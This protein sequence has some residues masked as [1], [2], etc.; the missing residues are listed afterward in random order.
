[1]SAHVKHALSLRELVRRFPHAGCLEAIVT[2]P[3]AR[4]PA[5]TVQEG[6]LEVGRGLVGDRR[7]QKFS[8]SAHQ[9]KRELTL[10][11]AEHLPLI[12]RRSDDTPPD[13]S[14][15]RRNLVVSGINLLAMRAPFAD[16]ALQW[17]IGSEAIIE[18]TGP[19][20]PCSRMEQEF[21]PGG[22]NA[23]RGHS[24]VTARVVRS[25]EVRVGNRIWLAGAAQVELWRR[26]DNGN[27]FL[28]E[29]FFDRASAEQACERF[30]RA[31]H[32]QLYWLKTLNPA[33][34]V[35]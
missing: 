26:D 20:D 29:R 35:Y 15:L 5:L 7:A 6:R 32:K 12:A 11:Q 9:R 33:N 16:L 31:G 30:T 17:A 19:C 8:E 27:E 22:Y 4:A 28:I 3:L 23:L 18:I 10:F 13:P 21:G 14:R 34:E 24:G 25:G 2:R 1:V